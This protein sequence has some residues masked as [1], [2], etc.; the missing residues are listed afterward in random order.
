MTPALL[1]QWTLGPLLPVLAAL[2]VLYV[3][4]ARRAR[5]WPARRT[6]AW[7]AGLLAIAVALASGVEAQDGRLLSAHMLQHLLL[8]VV[9]PPLLLVAAPAALTLRSVPRATAARVARLLRG[10]VLRAA[11]HPLVALPAF[12]GVTAVTH[13]T[14]LYELAI[15]HP[16]V[17][18][19]EH[20]A[21]VLTATMFWA[22]LVAPAPAPHRLRPIGALAYIMAAMPPMV[23][24]ALVLAGD[25]LRY[26]VYAGPGALADQHVAAALMLAG[27]V[28]SALALTF[29]V[30]WPALLRDERRA[31][32][33]TAAAAGGTR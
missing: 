25:T 1:T 24:I 21:Y 19:A 5:R 7:L 14:G 33:R 10:R 32:A 23:A 27:A 4:A 6:A 13:L 9:A 16:L 22:A 31:L 3:R 28:L 2:A 26:P 15:R 30:L 20:G 11:C 29:A 17:H 12:V 8:T 18:V